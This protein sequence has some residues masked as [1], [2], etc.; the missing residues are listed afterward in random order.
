MRALDAERSLLGRRLDDVA[1]REASALAAAA[2]DPLPDLRGSAEYK[3]A[4]A[5]VWTARALR[6]VA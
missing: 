4:M 3:R 1:V 2:T 6:E 5:G